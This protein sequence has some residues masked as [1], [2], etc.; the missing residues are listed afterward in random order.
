V[1]LTAE[2]REL[3]REIETIIR[4]LAPQLLDQPGIGPH[5]AAQLIL[6]RSHRGRIESEAAF[7]RLAGAAPIP[8]PRIASDVV[9]R[10]ML[11]RLVSCG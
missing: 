7:A 10:S 11:A 3:A 2:E 5:S 4:K 8:A 9:S 1:Q 6:S